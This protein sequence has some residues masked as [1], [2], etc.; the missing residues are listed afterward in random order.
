MP[1]TGADLS[2]FD[3]TDVVECTDC[4][5]RL[6]RRNAVRIRNVHGGTYHICRACLEDML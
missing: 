4:G 3:L 6:L 5:Y 1:A 2:D